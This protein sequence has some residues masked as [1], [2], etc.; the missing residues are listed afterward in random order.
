MKRKLLPREHTWVASAMED[1][2]WALNALDRFEEAQSLDTEA[3]VMR[4]K[5]LGDAHPDVP[6]NFNALGQLLRNRGDLQAAEG[7]LKAVLSIQRKMFG[8]DNQAT[9]ETFCSLAQA[10]QREGKRSE[11]ESVWRE[12]LAVWRK[13]GEMDKLD[14]LYALRGLGETLEEEG[15]WSEAEEV[16]RESLSLWRKRGGI[17]ERQSMYTLRKLGLVLEAERK[18][19]EAESVYREALTISR[20]KGNEDEEALVDLDRVVRALTAQKK[21]VEA[22]QLLDEILTP[23]FVAKP[24]SANLLVQ[25]VEVMGRRGRWQQ[26][27]VDVGFLLQ[28]Q[29]SEHYHYHRLAALLAVSQSRPAYEELCQKIVTLFTNTAN[30]YVDERVAQDCLLLPNS[31]VN[32][33]LID[34]LADAA[35]TIGSREAS[36]PYFQACKAMSTYRL[37]RFREAIEWAEKAT[38]SPTAEH[39]AKAKALGVSAM[40]NWQLGRKDA[41]RAA[42]AKGDASVLNLSREPD[43]VDLGESWVAWLMARISLDEATKLIRTEATTDETSNQNA[44]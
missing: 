7:V 24:T 37:G 26:A 27:A 32:L 38:K 20:R 9:L 11:A 33:E 40:A 12:A 30:P 41:A 42:L 35:V 8:D 25:R 28:L 17:E 21:F 36:L 19:P 10:L 13:R 44:K 22:Q 3:L 43:T 15:K 14:S 29:P 16:W 34:Q 23:T 6:R 31:G 39:Q 1:L 5:L 2:A 18:W 4:Q